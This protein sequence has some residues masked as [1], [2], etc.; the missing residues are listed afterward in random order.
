MSIMKYINMPEE[1]LAEELAR[2]SIIFDKPTKELEETLDKLALT[3]YVSYLNNDSEIY[4]NAAEEI[5]KY[6]ELDVNEVNNYLN[7]AFY[8]ASIIIL[9]NIYENELELFNPEK[10]SLKIKTKHDLDAERYI[11]EFNITK[12]EVELIKQYNIESNECYA[13]ETAGIK[14]DTVKP[15]IELPSHLKNNL[16]S[17]IY[18]VGLDSSEEAIE[19]VAKRGIG[20]RFL[21]SD[22]LKE[23]AEAENIEGVVFK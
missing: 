11:R 5:N 15:T 6:L 9:R 18:Y 10:P 12:S 20:F 19:S 3:Y 7:Y 16:L 4:L 13:L 14:H 22:K 8:K 17:N 1:E 21:C 23:M 2:Y